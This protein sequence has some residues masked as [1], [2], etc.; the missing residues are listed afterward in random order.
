MELGPYRLGREI[1]R[2]AFGIVF[3]A[4]NTDTGE[5]CAIKRVALA[6]L[7]LEDVEALHVEASAGRAG[8][9]RG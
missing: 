3:E 1:G 9:M 5:A 6:S 2:G 4:L 7:S 8:W